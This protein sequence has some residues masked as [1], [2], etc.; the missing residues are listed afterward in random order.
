M[1]A[2][3]DTCSKPSPGSQRL[4]NPEVTR[5]REEVDLEREGTRLLAGG[6]VTGGRPVLETQQVQSRDH[7]DLPQQS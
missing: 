2:D 5:L 4:L 1:L 3:L 7:P 6:F